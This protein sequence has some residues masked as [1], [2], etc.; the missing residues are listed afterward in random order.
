MDNSLIKCG[1]LPV[2]SNCSITATT[3]S[4]LIPSVSILRTLSDGE[5]GGV[6]SVTLLCGDCFGDADGDNGVSSCDL[7]SL[8]AG[9][10]RSGDEGLEFER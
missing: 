6:C 4:S 9:G 5:G 1:L 10:D 8:F 2:F 7:L 3:M